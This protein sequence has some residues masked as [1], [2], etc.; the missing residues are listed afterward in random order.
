[1]TVK[2]G[3]DWETGLPLFLSLLNNTERI[4]SNVSTTSSTI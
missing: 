4:L 3:E 2:K 1:M